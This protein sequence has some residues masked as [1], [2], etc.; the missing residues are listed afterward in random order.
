[1]YSHEFSDILSLNPSPDRLNRRA[2][3]KRLIEFDDRIRKCVRPFRQQCARFDIGHNLS[4]NNSP[5]A[6]ALIR[7]SPKNVLLL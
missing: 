3:G 1:M 4:T 7:M 5:I 6:Q 2:I